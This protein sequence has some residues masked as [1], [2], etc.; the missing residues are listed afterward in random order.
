MLVQLKRFRL[1]ARAVEGEHELRDEPL[2]VSV[3][4]DERTKL[5][6]EVVVASEGEIRVD[7][8]LQRTQALLLEACDLG[9]AGAEER[10]VGEHLAAPE[11]ER[12]PRELGSQAMMTIVRRGAGCRKEARRLEHVEESAAELESVAGAAPSDGRLMRLEKR[13]KTGDVTLDRVSGG[14]G[15]VLTPDVVDQPLDRNDFVRMQEQHGEHDA[16]LRASERH[17]DP[18]DADLE[19]PEDEEPEPRGHAHVAGV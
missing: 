18:V 5:T 1:P 4:V 3:L 17:R 19:W 10:C 8:L 9:G 16:L 11:P 12:F 15:R 7:P 13:A 2:T 14:S 6:H